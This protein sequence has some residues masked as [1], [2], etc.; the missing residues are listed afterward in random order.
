VKE[1]SEEALLQ[2]FATSFPLAAMTSVDL[3]APLV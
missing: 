2:V 1:A 3:S